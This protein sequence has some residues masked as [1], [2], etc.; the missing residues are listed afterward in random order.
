M[1]Q[2]SQFLTRRN[3]W[4]LGVVAPLVL[5]LAVT[6][7]LLATTSGLLWMLGVTHRHSRGN[8]QAQGVSGSLL[9]PIGIQQLVLRGEGWRVTLRG[10]FLDWHPTALLQG[11]LNVQNLRVREVDVLVLPSDK[12]AT[13]PASLRLPL[14]ISAAQIDI[15]VLSVFSRENAQ[16]DFSA[17]EIRTGF[18]SDDKL[19]RLQNLHTRLPLG[20]FKASAE[21]APDKPFALKAQVSLDAPVRL[22]GHTENTQLVA[23][24]LGDLNQLNVK[25]HGSGAGVNVTGTTQLAPFSAIFVSRVQASFSGLDLQRF[26]A[27]APSAEVAGSVDLR[28]LSGGVL[29][30]SMQLRNAHAA[31]LNLKGLPLL[32]ITAQVRLSPASWRLEQIDARLPNDGHITGAMTWELKHSKGIAQL[33]VVQLDAGALDTR[34]PKTRMQGDISLDGAGDNQ[35]AVVVL[36]DGKL[37]LFA[38]LKRQA[39]HVELSDFRLTR[40]ET[41]LSGHGQL[42]LDRRRTFRISSTL[43]KLNLSEFAATPPTELN[44]DLD[45]SGFVLPQMEGMLRFDLSKSRFAQHNISGNGHLEFAGLQRASGDVA[46]L[47]GDNRLNMN[48][49]LGTAADRIQLSLEAP[50]LEQL[51]NGLGGQLAGQATLSGS[52]D[53]P[54]LQFNVQGQQLVFSGEKH[55]DTLDVTGD[56]A[57]AAMQMKLDMKGL[58]NR[59]A[60]QIPHANF[61]LQG[62]G[63]QH[64]VT[65]AAQFAQGAETLEEITLTAH[66]GLEAAGQS[67][68]PG[69]WIGT[70]ESLGASGVLPFNLLA[71]A[72]LKFDRES[73]QLG[74]AH[75]S[76]GGGQVNFSDT[77]WTPQRWHSAGDFGSINLRA[78]NLQQEQPI[79]QAA[80]TMR[81]GGD[82]SVTAGEHWQGHFRAQRESGD[83]LVEGGTGLRLGLNDLQLSLQ[84]EQDQL[85]AKVHAQGERLGLVDAHAMLPLTHGTSGW[86]ILPQSVLSG[87]IQ[88]QSDDLSWLGP[89]L[90]GNLQSGGRLKL[91]A[92]LAGSF[93]APRLQGKAHGED[94]V[95]GLLDQGVSLHQGKLDMRFEPTAVFIDQLEFA[96]PLQTVPRDNLLRDFKLSAAAGKVSASG[97][98]DL[99]GGQ[100]SVQINAQHLP[101]AQRTDR[102]IIASGSGS[103]RYDRQ[104]LIFDGDIRADAGLINQPVNNRPRWADDML[105]VGLEPAVQSGASNSVRATLDLGDHFYIR[106]SGLEARLAGQLDVSSEDGEAVRV[107]GIIAA[108]DALFDA[109]GQRLQV[110][111]GMVNFQGPLDD[112]GLNILALRKG[113]SVEAGVEVTGTVRHPIVHLVSTPS[114]PDAEKLSWIVLGRVPDSSG[115]DT[116]LLIAA[117]GNILGGQSV[118]QL[119]RALGVDELSLKQQ[120][121][122]DPLLS[123]KVTVGK[124]IS[125]RAFISYEQGLSDVGGVTKFTYTLSPRFTLITRTGTEDALELFYSFRFY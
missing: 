57:E 62:S 48:V 7:W 20:D 4:L 53:I 96:A 83:W 85:S 5:L 64:T 19:I 32:G 49:L 63:K 121:G 2:D 58:R 88:V 51:G 110:D 73:L 101:L 54:R 30:G 61:E 103:A 69:L 90:D 100:G 40:G 39:E 93:L 31:P 52:V 112:P 37:A 68:T 71:P 119:G 117:A 123:Q 23:D 42:A 33:K 102:W 87:R 75:V 44:A 84:V 18:A 10:V 8:I 55:L 16:P 124:R 27:G 111:R 46:V 45:V 70:L 118:G 14:E 86:T 74:K 122:G 81:F 125:S 94:L 76:I 35:H 29:Q 80:E 108:Q 43:R 115:I 36:G 79:P 34:L 78:V 116:T 97:R 15:N 11:K 82:W 6:V 60:V 104:R 50:K 92:D 1:Q 9:E 114:V 47:L 22:S 12:P 59:G 89:M 113:L 56:L 91:D 66:G 98:F 95:F 3:K 105:M 107:T 13:L 65:V 67:S 21:I 38:D 25:L 99:E 72:A 41:V 17:S 106:A 77:S 24:V 26:L 109:F 28:G 120:A